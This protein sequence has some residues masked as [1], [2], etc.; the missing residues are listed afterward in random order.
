ME[1]ATKITTEQL[2]EQLAEKQKLAEERKQK[3]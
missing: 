2:T 3:V 1:S